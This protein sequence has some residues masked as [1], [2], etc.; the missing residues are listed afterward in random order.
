MRVT[1]CFYWRITVEVCKSLVDIIWYGE[2][3]SFMIII[4]FQLNSTENFTIPIKSDIIVF[5]LYL[6]DGLHYISHKQFVKVVD[7]KI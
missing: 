6:C 2:V 7:C 3:N 1:L 4:P 5:F